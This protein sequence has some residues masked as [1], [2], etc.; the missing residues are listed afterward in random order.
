MKKTFQIFIA[1]AIGIGCLWLLFRN[2]DWGEVWDSFRAVNLGLLLL[3]QIPLYLTFFLRVQRWSYI[4]RAVEPASYRHLFSATQIG[5]LANFVLPLRAGEIVRPLALS[6]LTGM[7]FSKT[8]AMNALDRVTDLFGLIAVFFVAVLC[9]ST[10]GEVTIPKETFGMDRDFH[11]SPGQIQVGATGTIMFL[12]AIVAVLA[13]LYVRKDF[14]LR[15]SD[16]IL[17]L[18]SHRLAERVRGIL[19]QFAEGLHVFKS[20]SDMAKAISF[21]LL[22]WFVGIIAAGIIFS[23]FG[24]DWPWYTPFVMQALLAVAISVPSTPGFVGAFHIPIVITLV[25]LIPETSPDKAKAVAILIHL[26]NVVA[27]YLLGIYAL[28]REDL[29]LFQLTRPKPETD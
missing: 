14:T 2:T 17:G 5:F 18:V 26:L 19:E 13:L 15:L 3:A 29:N 21:S 23:S 9:V 4:V 20:A 28:V 12:V 27:V 7:T 8:F 16:K 11:F 24:I 22:T 10:A 1:L 25:M 6:R